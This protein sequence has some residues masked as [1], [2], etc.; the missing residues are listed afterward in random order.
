M[1]NQKQELPMSGGD[2]GRDRIA[3]GFTTMCAISIATKVVSLNPVHGE[4][5]T[6]QHYLIK[7]VSDL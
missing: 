5:H 2:C 4:V 1:T 6:I 3:V 7:F